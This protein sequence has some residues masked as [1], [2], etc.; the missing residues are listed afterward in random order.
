M[1]ECCDSGYVR[2]DLDEEGGVLLLQESASSLSLLFHMLHC[3]LEPYEGAA[4]ASDSDADDDSVH[5][6]Q[7]IPASA[8]PFPLLPT[9]FALADKY[10]FTATIMNV[11]QS[12]LFAYAST[13]PL[14]VYGLAVG[15]GLDRIAAETSQ[16]L[17]RPPLT[18]YATEQIK[19]IPTAEAYHRLVLLHEYRIQRLSA[20]LMEEQIFPQRYGECSKHASRTES[21]W[22][23]K[24]KQVVNQIHAGETSEH[25]PIVTYAQELMLRCRH[26]CWC[27]N[28]SGH[29]PA[30]RLS[31]LLQSLDRGDSDAQSESTR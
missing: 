13:Y 12:H 19:V 20:L 15:M 4:G 31:D 7:R 5:I 25:I 16:Y 26:R 1:F 17:L 22:D 18:T 21:L 3:T 10:V 29:A 23:T 8:I 9:L 30:V 24:R 2:D 28:G 6:T 14:Q 27:R 11:C